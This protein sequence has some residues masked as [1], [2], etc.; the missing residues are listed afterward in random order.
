MEYLPVI[1]EEDQVKYRA[2]KEICHSAENPLRHRSVTVM[3]FK[4][5]KRDQILVQRR[6][7]YKKRKPGLLE[8]T[9]GHVAAGETYREAAEREYAEELFDCTPEEAPFSSE[10]LNCLYK[11]DKESEDNLEKIK[12]YSTVQDRSFNLSDEVQ[13]AYFEPIEEV[14][15]EAS[16]HPQNYTNS[17]L[18]ALKE[19]QDS[20][21]DSLRDYGFSELHNL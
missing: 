2:R 16:K 17:A 14:L 15:K 18:K 3:T 10:E 7:P 19:Y 6:S 8:L 9:S 12:V 1:D 4:S 20:E 5:E 21:R 13:E 11:L